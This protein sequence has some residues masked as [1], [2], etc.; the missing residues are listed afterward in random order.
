MTAGVQQM[1]R[2]VLASPRY[3][4]AIAAAFLL[5]ACGDGGSEE[6]AAAASAP[7]VIA[8][9]VPTISGAPQRSVVAGQPY[10]FSPA[11]SDGDGD[12]LTFGITGKPS[13]ATFSAATGRLSG[14]P[15]SADIGSSVVT[16]RVTDGAADAVLAAFTLSVVGTA[17]GSATITWMAPTLNTNGS[18]LTN[19]AGYKLYWGTD[20]NN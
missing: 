15:T 16:I 7:G 11:A 12:I 2:K 14:T 18:A 13:W 19:L 3:L 10:S 9:A 4:I 8:N 1:V 20:Q 17:A 5:A 6:Q